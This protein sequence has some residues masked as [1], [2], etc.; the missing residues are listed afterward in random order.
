[1]IRTTSLGVAATVLLGGSALAHTFAGWPEVERSLRA[2]SVSPDI[3]G[4]TAAGWT[5]GSLAMAVFAT[6]VG[7]ATSDARRGR[8]R[9]LPCLSIGIAYVGFG[10]LGYW[11][12][13]GKPHFLG[14]FALG[15]LILG[16]T[17]SARSKGRL[18]APGAAVETT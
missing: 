3:V 5:F 16:F 15:L 12:R 8:F 13:H 10:A 7:A 1:M 17:A 18:P 2:A 11:L 14:F 9:A 6:I 4:G